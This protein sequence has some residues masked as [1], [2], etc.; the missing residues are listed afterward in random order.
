MTVHRLIRIACAFACTAGTLMSAACDDARPTPAGPSNFLGP[1]VTSVSPGAGAADGADNV[2]I[3]GSRFLPGATV[4]MDGAATNVVVVN[5]TTITATTPAHVA[6][7]V[8]VIVTNPDG[9]SSRL[10]GAFTF[11]DLA[12]TS[13]APAFAR[14][15]ETV[16]ILG[17]GFNV[18][19]IVTMGGVAARILSSSNSS[20]INVVAPD[21]DGGLA[22]VVVTNL[23]G[24]SVT[25]TEGFRFTTITI[26]V[27]AD[28]VTAGGELA[29]S[30]IVPDQGE[31][32]QVRG[33]EDAISLWS[34]NTGRF[35]WG[36]ETTGSPSGTRTLAAPAE[37]GQYEFQYRDF[38][39]L[40][41]P[42]SRIIG[43]S[44]LITVTAAPPSGLAHTAYGTQAAR[45]R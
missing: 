22:D 29:V 40:R 44:R 24:R 7:V 36:E 32:S 13:V 23:G 38:S 2:R 3:D 9:K 6:G 20:A 1:S 37:P 14:S 45:T 5:S 12:V 11:A 25:L 33:A 39:E 21:R 19:A 17:A 35:V 34:I 42:N 30:W 16:R 18:G 43:R 41:N 8:A 26:S 27:S 10:P 31:S 4:T 28:V 15:G